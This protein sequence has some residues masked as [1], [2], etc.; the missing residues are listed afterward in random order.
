MLAKQHDPN[1]AADYDDVYM[2]ALERAVDSLN[3]EVAV[4]LCVRG[5][6]PAKNRC[7]G[8]VPTMASI[9]GG[10]PE[11]V[12]TGFED[13]FENYT[14]IAGFPGL[15]ALLVERRDH[16]RCEHMR[17]MLFLVEA[18]MVHSWNNK[19]FRH[20]QVSFGAGAASRMR[21]RLRCAL[22][23]LNRALSVIPEEFNAKL[24]AFVM[25]E[26]VEGALRTIARACA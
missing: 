5:A 15:H 2:S 21:V 11:D 17:S 12:R 25:L 20:L 23:C 24:A 16:H 18:S 6:D 22:I 3:V 4:L 9:L 26:E 14:P 13:A 10:E 8:V 19:L 7:V 1:S